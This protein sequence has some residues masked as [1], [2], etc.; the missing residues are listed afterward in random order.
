[1]TSPTRKPEPDPLIESLPIGVVV[2]AHGGRIISANVRAQE[3]LGRSARHLIGQPLV[4]LLGDDLE[5]RFAALF[6]HP[7]DAPSPPLDP[8]RIYTSR[9]T[10]A[11]PASHPARREPTH[12]DLAARAL[13]TTTDTI[14]TLAEVSTAVRLERDAAHRERLETITLMLRGLAHEVRNPLAGLKGM[15]QL[16][17]RGTNLPDTDREMLTIAMRESERIERLLSRLATVASRPHDTP[18]VTVNIHET[19]KSA[20]SLV[21]AEFPRL[22]IE[23]NYD[24]SLPEVQGYPD[25]LASLMLNLVRN[26]AQAVSG[27]GTLRIATG[28][29]DRLVGA[30][31]APGL[32][33]RQ[34]IA[35]QIHD[36]GP[37]VA[38]ELGEK[39]FEAFVTSRRDGQGLGLALCRTIVLAHRGTIDFS[40]SPLGGACFTVVLPRAP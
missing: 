35:I 27:S 33:A 20:I 11:A 7:P 29:A 23:Q 38:P 28:R 4:T 12:I 16:V 3:I 30:K 34:Q 26:A 8:G 18:P 24:T 6:Q 37:G 32:Q 21:A 14:V 40:R 36:D 31:P 15:L 13:G 19:L 10:L 25:E 2:V 9:V 5:P 39:I 1:M 22:T 17:L